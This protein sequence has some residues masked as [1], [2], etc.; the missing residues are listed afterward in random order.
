ME[1]TGRECGLGRT[2]DWGFGILSLR[3][4][5]GPGAKGRCGRYETGASGPC[6][7]AL[8]VALEDSLSVLVV[9]MGRG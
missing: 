2:Q 6:H 9:V 4:G 8:S 1:R 5:R 7:P 3:V